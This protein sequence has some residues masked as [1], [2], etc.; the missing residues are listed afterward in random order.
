[1]EWRLFATLAQTADTDTVVL[2]DGDVGTVG[3]AL[4]ALLDR[5][6]DLREEVLENGEVRDHLRV[7]VDGDDPF[8]QAEGMDTPVDED[9]EL[10]LFPP[11]SGG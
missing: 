10:A 11:V 5:H 3:E 4:D 1:M 8:R 9:T 2:D 7:L 6:P